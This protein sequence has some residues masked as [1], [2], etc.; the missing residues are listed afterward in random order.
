MVLETFVVGVG[1]STITAAVDVTVNGGIDT[2]GIAAIDRS[3]NVVTAIDI[4]DFTSTYEYTCRQLGR[5]AVARQVRCRLIDAAHRW[6]DICHTTA[7]IDILDNQVLDVLHRVRCDFQQQTLRTRHTTLVTAGVEVADD[8]LL[9]IP[10][11][12]DGHLGL[13]V[14]AKDTG[15][16]EREIIDFAL[17][18]RE[19]GHRLEYIND[20]IWSDGVLCSVCHNVFQTVIARVIDVDGRVLTYCRLVAAAIDVGYVATFNLQ[21]GLVDIGRDKWC[22][23]NGDGGGFRNAVFRLY[24]LHDIVAGIVSQ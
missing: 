5:E 9:Q 16:V 11:R 10:C 8:A 24:F 14:A 20:R 18:R 3:R 4:I 12:T 21:I 19:L 23:L 17:E 2:D 6:F 22:G 7:A 15:V 13:V 1:V